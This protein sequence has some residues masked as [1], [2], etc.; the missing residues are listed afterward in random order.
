[1]AHRTIP[2]AFCMS[3][4]QDT[5]DNDSAYEFEQHPFQ[6]GGYMI[7]TNGRHLLCIPTD[8]AAD[9]GWLGAI[10]AQDNP[11]V[12]NVFPDIEKAKKF[13]LAN[14]V[15]ITRDAVENV[16][17]QIPVDRIP[18]LKKVECSECHGRGTVTYHYE[19][20]NRDDYE[21]EGECPICDGSGFEEIEDSD[22][23][24]E[25]VKRKYPVLVCGMITWSREILWL[26]KVM[27]ALDIDRL[28]V[29]YAHRGENCV[30]CETED[31][32]RVLFTI[33]KYDND[34][35]YRSDSKMALTLV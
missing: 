17:K 23:I 5:C 22:H 26:R 2:S 9:S 32:I 29:M 35:Q 27:D 21:L 3:T 30:Y 25:V 18:G 12:A 1:M 24:E 28:S 33:L 8:M 13:H 19:S 31:G 15:V 4:L 10:P 20:N 14:D 7:A 34:E 16:C 6:Q 11:K